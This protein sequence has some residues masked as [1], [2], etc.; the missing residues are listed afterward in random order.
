MILVVAVVVILSATIFM[1]L[2]NSQTLKTNDLRRLEHGVDYIV[3]LNESDN[4]AILIT[5]IAIKKKERIIL[6]YRTKAVMYCVKDI[7][8]YCNDEDIQILLLQKIGGVSEE[9]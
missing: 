1:C 8:Q 7:Q 6:P 9:I 4:S 2:R 5:A 3:D